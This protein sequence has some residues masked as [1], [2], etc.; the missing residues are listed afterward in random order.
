[1]ISRSCAN[2]KIC[3]CYSD[4]DRV[5][6]AKL[7][8]GEFFGKKVMNITEETNVVGETEYHRFLSFIDNADSEKF[9]DRAKEIIKKMLDVVVLEKESDINLS[10]E[11]FESIMGYGD[12]AFGGAGEHRGEGA[13]IEAVKQAVSDASIDFDSLGKISAIVHFT[14]PPGRSIMEISES[15]HRL[16]QNAECEWLLFG[17]TVDES[18]PENCVAVRILATG[19]R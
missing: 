9:N 16:E 17:M 18:L 2:G 19:C 4:Y 8:I 13:A 6:H 5:S 7:L 12:V 15:M 1:M 14:V 10:F 11:D 3:R